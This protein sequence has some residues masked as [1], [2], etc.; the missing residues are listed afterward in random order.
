LGV[1]TNL[2]CQSVLTTGIPLG[3]KQK[4]ISEDPNQET[5]VGREVN[6]LQEEEIDDE[7]TISPDNE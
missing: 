6:L 4:W 2:I 5:P 3:E 7:R 1:A